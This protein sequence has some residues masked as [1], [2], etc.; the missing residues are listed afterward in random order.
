MDFPRSWR[1]L[2][3]ASRTSPSDD[4]Y[5]TYSCATKSRVIVSTHPPAVDNLRGPILANGV[6]GPGPAGP[7][8]GWGSDQNDFD[9]RTKPALDNGRVDGG[10]SVGTRHF[11]ANAKGIAMQD[12]ATM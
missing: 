1:N 10:K 8:T 11:T 5:F 4:R 2:R 3:C 9:N 7:P 12:E 6:N